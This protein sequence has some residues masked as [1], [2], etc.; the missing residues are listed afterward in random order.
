MKKFISG[1]LFGVLL[2]FSFPV[3]ANSNE[4][5]AKFTNFNF[6]VNGQQ[7]AIEAKPIVINGYSYLPLKDTALMLGYD[8]TYKADSRTIV[9]KSN[10]N[11]L[12]YITKGSNINNSTTNDHSLLTHQELEAL[13]ID[14]FGRDKMSKIQFSSNKTVS[15]AQLAGYLT[16]L[17]DIKYDNEMSIPDPISESSQWVKISVVPLYEKGVIDRDFIE[18]NIHSGITKEDAIKYII[19]AKEYK[20]KSK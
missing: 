12:G 1:I 3:L 17:L 11:E 8:I 10:K 9:L 13:F 5:L 15:K 7:K 2:T 14:I 16:L 4:I 6:I 18:S 20:D 19:K